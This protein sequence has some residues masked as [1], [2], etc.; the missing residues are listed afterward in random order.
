[1]VFFYKTS[2][3]FKV[4]EFE[5]SFIGSEKMVILCPRMRITKKLSISWVIAGKHPNHIEIA[6]LPGIIY[7]FSLE[8]S[9]FYRLQI[10][11]FDKN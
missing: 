7:F 6:D 4:K 11:F 3:C 5:N 1:M 2:T 10:Y 9:F 8:K